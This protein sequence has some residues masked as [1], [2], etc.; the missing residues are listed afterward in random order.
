MNKLVS[1]FGK[2]TCVCVCVAGTWAC[3][4]FGLAPSPAHLHV[5]LLVPTTVSLIALTGAIRNT[6]RTFAIHWLCKMGH[7][8]KCISTCGLVSL[9]APFQP[10][11][12]LK[13][14]LFSTLE[15]Y[16]PIP[17]SAPLPSSG[18]ITVL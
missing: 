3:V 8:S 2:I 9:L 6:V 4:A 5:Q 13:L 7:L 18:W 1:G 10:D 11:P 17:A 12:A 16:M 14:M 15:K